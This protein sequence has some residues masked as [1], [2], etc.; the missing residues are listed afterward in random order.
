MIEFLAIAFFSKKIR[1]IAEQKN[2]KASKWIW[3][4]IL[5]WFGVEIG[6]VVLYLILTGDDFES[7]VFIFIPAMLL[8]ALSGFFIVKQLE[9]EPEMHPDSVIIK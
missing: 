6:T 4:F 5:T 8:A 3:K 9:K 7:S 2:I 1:A